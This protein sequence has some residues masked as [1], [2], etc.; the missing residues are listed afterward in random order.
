WPTLRNWLDEDADRRVIRD[1][2]STSINEWERLG[3]KRDALWNGRQ[4]LEAQLLERSDLLPRERLFLAASRRAVRVR[5]RAALGGLAGLA[6]ALGATYFAVQLK[7]TRDL[8]DQVQIKMK[9]GSLALDQARE[10]NKIVET[11]RAQAF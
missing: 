1:R 10:K 2:L 9:E 6:L 5:R 3:R 4:L 7:V 11:L 8:N